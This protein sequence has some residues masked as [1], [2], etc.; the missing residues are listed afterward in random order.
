MI[1]AIFNQKG[2]VG[3]STIACNLAAAGARNER[4]QQCHSCEAAHTSQT[5]R[6]RVRFPRD[7]IISIFSARHGRLFSASERL[8]H[9]RLY[10]IHR[11]LQTFERL[12]SKAD[13]KMPLATGAIERSGFGRDEALLED[14]CGKLLG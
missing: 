6:R 10:P 2:G 5:L 7:A 1:R 12:G 3:K 4:Q 13:A 8:A 14:V 9:V 11:H